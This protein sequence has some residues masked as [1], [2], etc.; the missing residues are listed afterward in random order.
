[1]HSLPLADLVIC[2]SIRSSVSDDGGSVLAS[3]VY[4]LT[5]NIQFHKK[6]QTP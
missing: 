2:M 4:F 6:L 3:C 1:M 5:D